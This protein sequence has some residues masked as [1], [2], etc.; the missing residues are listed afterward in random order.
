MDTFQSN[1]Q[2]CTVPLCCRC[3][4]GPP[5]PR[6]LPGIP[7]LQ[8]PK[9]HPGPRGLPGIPGLRGPQGSSGPRGLPGPRGPQGSPGPLAPQSFAQL[10]DRNYTNEVSANNTFLNLSNSGISPLYTTGGYSLAT[11]TVN[12]DTLNL[13]GPGIYHFD[14][15]L[16]AS[17]LYAAPAPTF[18]LSYQMLFNIMNETNFTI[19]SMIYEGIIPND[20]DTAIAETQLSLSFLYN[21]DAAIPGFKIAVGN[22]NYNYAFNNQLFVYDII[23]VVQKWQLPA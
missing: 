17:F 23:I 5:G 4:I 8:G 14:V 1:D 20:A 10:F 13:P 22:F 11:T 2:N 7:G 12:N 9:G 3:I 19:N 15:S 16:K 21:T 18:G 6:G